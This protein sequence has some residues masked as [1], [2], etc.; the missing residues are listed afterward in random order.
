MWWLTVGC[1]RPDGLDEVAGAHLVA[2]GGGDATSAAAADR[3][4]RGRRTTGPAVSAV[5]LVEHFGSDRCAAGDRIEHGGWPWACFD[6]I[7]H[8]SK[9][10][11]DESSIHSAYVIA[12]TFVN[13]G[14]TRRIPMSRVQLALNVADLDAVDRVLHQAVPD[15]SGEDP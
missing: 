6:C 14:L 10:S 15:P 9:K 7:E 3:I 5:G 8:S 4:G 11:I 2:V 13:V 1:E 12:S